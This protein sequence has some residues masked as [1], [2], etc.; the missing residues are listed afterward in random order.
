MPR[1]IPI[2]IR[3]A[4][5]RR[6]RRGQSPRIIAEDLGLPLRTVRRLVR[7]LRH[8]GEDALPP[9]YGHRR[10][11][12]APPVCSAAL[13]MRRQHPRWGAP[14]IRVLLARQLPAADLPSA[15][16]LQRW[17]HQAGLG[18]APQGRHPRQDSRRASRPHAVWQ[19][20]AVE[21]VRLASGQRVCWLR[22]IDEKSGAVLATAVF[23][24]GALVR[25]RRRRRAS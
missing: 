25:S 16:T 2:P 24:P 22:L 20:D 23:P 10:C 14:L 5:L 4:I 3:R 11:P 18:P 7:R 13:A 17:F 9:D 19:M 1:P 12:P 6:L 8:G 21:R 15:R